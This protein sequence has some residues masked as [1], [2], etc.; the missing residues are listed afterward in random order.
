MLAAWAVRAGK[1]DELKKAIDERKGQ[2]LAE[3]PA[4]I[5]TAQLALAAGDDPS[6]IA[7]LKALA[8]RLK[9]D[10]LRTTA[11]LACHAAMPALD[12]PRPEVARAAIEVLDGCAKG[13]ESDYQPEPLGTMLVLL[14]RRQL[15][16]GDI[17]GAA[18]GSSPTWRP[19]RRTPAGTAATTR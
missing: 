8:E 6:A 1:A 15:Q 9:R 3:L 12:R 18:S 17:A 13:F 7:A 11:E 14:A 4:T 16:L 19:W 2:P 5:L 10:T